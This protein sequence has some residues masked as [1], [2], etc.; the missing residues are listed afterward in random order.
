MGSGV[1]DNH[2]EEDDKDQ[3]G[4]PGKT[5]TKDD[6]EEEVKNTITR[7]EFMWM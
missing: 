7:A 2:K 1:A 4:K 5:E 3:V 6:Q